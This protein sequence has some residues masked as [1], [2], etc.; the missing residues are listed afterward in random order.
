[1]L[2]AYLQQLAAE[3]PRLDTSELPRVVAATRAMIAASIAPSADA[4]AAAKGPIELVQ[5]SRIRALIHRHLG[6]ATLGPA[7]L[8]RLAGM[9]RSALYRLFVSRGGVAHYIQMERLRAASRA[10]ANPRDRRGIAEIAQDTGF[11]EPSTFSRTFRRTFGCTP[12]EFRIAALAGHVV[13]MMSATPESR[14]HDLVD[15]LHRL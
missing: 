14:P 3:L 8:C 11:F 15:V 12:R 5:I 9:S 10:L 13:P 6:S 1:M 7:L 4:M 2:A